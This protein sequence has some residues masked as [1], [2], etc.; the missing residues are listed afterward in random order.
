MACR[1]QQI[2]FTLAVLAILSISDYCFANDVPSEETLR[3][4][5]EESQTLANNLSSSKIAPIFDNDLDS[6]KSS[7]LKDS[8]PFYQGDNIP[9]A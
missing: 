8:M 3:K 5:K 7:E 9:N 6:S 1:I 4:Y 2:I